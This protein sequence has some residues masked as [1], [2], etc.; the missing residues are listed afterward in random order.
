M[1]AAGTV[2]AGAD[3]RDRRGRV[4][5]QW[6]RG[7]Q[8][9][10]VHRRRYRRADIEVRDGRIAALTDGVKAAADDHVLDVDGA[11]LLPGLIDCHVHMC[12]PSKNSDRRNTW[13][14]ALPGTIAI[15]AA[16]S[17]RRTLLGGTTTV[18]DVGGWDYP[19]DRGPQCH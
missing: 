6:I 19:R 14:G 7:G 11:F 4:M 18:R 10:D 9:Y 3:V 12:S 17:A 5:S 2:G 15:H 13:R 8:V 16:Q 1:P